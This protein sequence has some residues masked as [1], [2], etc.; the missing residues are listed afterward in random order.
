ME[1]YLRLTDREWRAIEPHLPP[2]RSG[3]RRTND[4]ETVAAFLFAAAAKVSLDSL[5]DCGFPNPLSL[6]NTMARW[7]ARGELEPVMRAGARAQER[8]GRQY[9]QHLVALLMRRRSADDPATIGKRSESMPRWT[10]SR[11]RV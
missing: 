7:R 2:Q 5:P 11:P 9:R 8:M 1:P 6:R 10:H 4:R 3:P